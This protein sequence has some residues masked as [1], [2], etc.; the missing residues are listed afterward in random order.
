M[1]S[2]LPELHTGWE[3]NEVLVESGDQF[4]RGVDPSF[5][6]LLTEQRRSTDGTLA[7]LMI[8]FALFCFIW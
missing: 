5:G 2:P 3:E 8:V 6:R 7:V 1:N 4:L